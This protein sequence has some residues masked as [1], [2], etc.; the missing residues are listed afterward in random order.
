MLRLRLHPVLTIVLPAATALFLALPLAAQ[1]QN[2]SSAQSP[3]SSATQQKKQDKKDN[4]GKKDSAQQ[5]NPFPEAQSEK[6]AQQAQQARRQNPPSA[7]APQAAPSSQPKQGTSTADQN[8]FPE[9]E[10][11]KAA[12]EDQQRQNPAPDNQG[13]NS[14]QDSSSSAVKG[15]NLTTTEDKQ[16]APG[17][18]LNPSLGLQ[19]TKVGTFYLQS[20]DWKGAYSRFLEATQVDP[21][22]AEA[23]YG[24]AE[25]AR[26]LG[27]R[28]VAIRNF[29]LYLS[30]IPR[31]Q[32]AKDCRKA[33]K[34]MGARP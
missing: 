8:P 25:S 14:S 10:S 28:K 30:A 23:V 4:A 13:S 11:E 2:S 29:Q 26:Q 27:Y 1:P 19:D 9:A 20:G 12:K 32:H 16:F 33:L 6:A 31:G 17:S 15:L 3:S 7:P 24:L 34:E 18:A 21:G 5:Q 22:D